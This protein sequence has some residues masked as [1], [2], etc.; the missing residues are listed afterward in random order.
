MSSNTAET[1]VGILLPILDRREVNVQ[2][3]PPR[4]HS[5]DRLET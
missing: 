2:L 1:T 5:E 4:F 3:S